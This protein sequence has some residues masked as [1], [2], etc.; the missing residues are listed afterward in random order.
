VEKN[1]FWKD[2]YRKDRS[3]SPLPT[4]VPAGQNGGYSSPADAVDG[5]QSPRGFGSLYFWVFLVPLLIPIRL[6]ITH[7]QLLLSG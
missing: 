2:E 4:E 1:T 7:R 3:K 5:E 6:F